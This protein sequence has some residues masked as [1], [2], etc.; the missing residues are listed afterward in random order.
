MT[1]KPSK[2]IAFI[3]IKAQSNVLGNKINNALNNVIESG[4]FI[5]GKEVDDLE[6]RLSNYCGVKHTLSCSSG[7]DALVLVL[8]AKGIGAGDAVFVPSF[9]FVA[10]AEAV[11]LVGAT[12]IFVDVR[13]D[14]FNMDVDDFKKA[15]KYAKEKG[16]KA[17]A[18]IPVDIFG[19]PADYDSIIPVAKEENLI[20]IADS[21]QSFGASLNGKKVGSIGDFSCTSFFP[22]KP[23]GCY[24]DG[25]AVFFNDDNMVEALK[26][27]RI[28]GMGKEKYDNIRIGINGR[29]DTMQ[30]AILLLKMD[31]FDDELPKRNLVAKRYRDGLPQYTH[32]TII[33]GAD[34][35]WAQY[36]MLVDKRDELQAHLKEKD[37]PTAAYYPKPVH[38]QTAY[39]KYANRS[40]PVSEMLAAKVISP[41]MHPYLDENT[42]DYIIEAFKSF[43]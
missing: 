17:K 23:L 18:V 26:S 12:P 4:A 35:V 28:H 41:P 7:T 25:G 15:L 11:V 20:V 10:T 30:A 34:S 33:K 8:M 21:A 36:T 32:Q 24:G 22:A 1:S 38:M 37:V 9:T 39:L 40:L 29:L 42:Q 16:L 5:M 31:I 6:K 13:A 43:K 27:I 19:Q 3:D 14:T 2:P